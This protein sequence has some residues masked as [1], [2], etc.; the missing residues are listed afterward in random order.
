MNNIEEL[1]PLMGSVSYLIKQIKLADQLSK[2]HNS[3]L[4]N[5]LAHNYSE[6]V[7]P[8][9][10]LEIEGERNA[11]IEYTKQYEK[12]LESLKKSVQELN[13]ALCK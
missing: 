11:V 3:S 7:F 2:R 5:M 1:K 12:H 10:A 6:H 9:S 8:F 13:M 4:D